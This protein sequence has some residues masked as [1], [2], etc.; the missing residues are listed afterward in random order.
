MQCTQQLRAE[1]I[2]KGGGILLRCSS[3]NEAEFQA[4]FPLSKGTL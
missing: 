3:I 4:F 2:K 1:F